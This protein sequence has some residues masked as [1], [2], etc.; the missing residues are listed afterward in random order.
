VPDMP[1]PQFSN[2]SSNANG[3]KSFHITSLPKI[4]AIQPAPFSKESYSASIEEAEYKSRVHSMIRWRY[5]TSKNGGDG[6]ASHNEEKK[7]RDP[8][9]GKLIKESNASIIKWSDGSF[10]LRV[11]NEM[12]D[13]DEFSFLL[14]AKKSNKMNKFKN[15]QQQ[16]HQ[17]HPINGPTS[18]DF[19]YLTQ[20]ASIVPSAS[21][22]SSPDPSTITV[23]Q[24]VKT[25]RSKFIPRPSSLHSAAHKQFALESKSRT[26][27]RAKIKTHVSFIDPEKQKQERIRHKDDL[28]KQESRS[29]GATR[30]SYGTTPRRKY[31]RGYDDD[32]DGMY[33]SVN[34]RRLKKG[35]MMDEDDMAYGDDDMQSDD[36]DEWS[37]RKK[38]G[39]ESQRKKTS[40]RKRGRFEFDEESEDEEEEFD[41]D[42]DD[43][44]GISMRK[45][46]SVGNK[47][48]AA[49][50]D[51]DDDSE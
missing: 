34:I 23:L 38:K 6:N 25:L 22:S 11:G 43:D 1:L 17:Q 4:V 33:D 44:E 37:K 21:Q 28:M 31:N 29:G 36:E 40:S 12:F 20:T 19:L 9:T 16:Q 5:K 47:R 24:A 42:D 26:L 15:E 13:M 10:G 49:V 14:N 45:K 7:E 30:R 50:F 35:T 32:D 8:E 51:D 39:F 27:Q 2:A 18:K 3:K 41:D 46:A 48:K